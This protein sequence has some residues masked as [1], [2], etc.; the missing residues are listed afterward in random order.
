MTLTTTMAIVQQAEETEQQLIDRA[1]RAESDA[2]WVV[3]E[4]AFLW[5]ERYAGKRT[6]SAFADL[7]GL[8]RK[9]VQQRRTVFSKF[10]DLWKS[11]SNLTWTHFLVAFDWSDAAEWL[12]EADK[13]GWSVAEMK[14]QRA[15]TSAT[16]ESDDDDDPVAANVP[17]VSNIASVDSVQQRSDETATERPHDPAA[18][19]DEGAA[20]GQHERD[21]VE[22]ERVRGLAVAV[23]KKTVPL[24]QERAEEINSHLKGY[25]KEFDVKR[26]KQL[27]KELRTIFLKGEGRISSW[28]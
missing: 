13:N 28:N 14:R 2:A 6:D 19:P 7:S 11:L 12:G 8:S 26:V 5:C 9:T 17:A 21:R 24:I 27:A 10:G 4:C 25:G 22:A 16:V 20:K 1:S 18:A 15:E 23:R 3:G